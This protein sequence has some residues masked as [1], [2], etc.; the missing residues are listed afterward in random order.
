MKLLKLIG[1]GRYS[2]IYEA[3]DTDGE[4]VAVKV[5]DKQMVK[6]LSAR[7]KT[8]LDEIQNEVVVLS[9]LNHVNVLKLKGHGED[10]VSYF[11]VYEYE[12]DTYDL[13]HFMTKR[14]QADRMF[15]VPP[16]FAVHILAQLVNALEYIHNEGV[17]HRDIKPEN[18]VV[19]KSGKM[20]VIDFG[21]CWDE[22]STTAHARFAGTAQF[23]PPEIIRKQ[24]PTSNVD[25][26]ALGCVAYAMLVGYHAFEAETEYLSMKKVESMDY[27]PPDSI[28]PDAADLI[29]KLLQED[30]NNRIGAN[31]NIAQIK[32]HK[33]FEGVDFA[34]IHDTPISLE[35]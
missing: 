13:I 1:E 22:R 32:N 16:A 12:Q 2:Q 17:I 19:T 35:W 7:H 28:P 26:W 34:T 21:T 9:R 8:L 27:A 30:P 15:W 10:K 31:G 4:I 6:R 33:F 20:I 14:K 29:V 11:R 24:D 3:K 25:L 23:I 5:M 18:L